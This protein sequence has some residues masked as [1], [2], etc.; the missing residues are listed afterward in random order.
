MIVINLGMYYFEISNSDDNLV[1]FCD[2]YYYYD[3]LGSFVEKNINLLYVKVGG[4]FVM[5]YYVL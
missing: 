3:Y 4:V 1:I 2:V 5:Y